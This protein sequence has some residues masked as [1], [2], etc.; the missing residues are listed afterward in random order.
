[1]RV[2]LLPGVN[3]DTIDWMNRQGLCEG[4]RAGFRGNSSCR[5]DSSQRLQQRPGRI[6]TCLSLVYR[7]IRPIFFVIIS[8]TGKVE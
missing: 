5:R 3:P 6:R 4:L 7:M 2:L 1:M 8:K